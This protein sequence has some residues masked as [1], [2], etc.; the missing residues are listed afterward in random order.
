MTAGP[1]SHTTGQFAVV[2]ASSVSRRASAELYRRWRTQ[3]RRDYP[4]PH[5]RASGAHASGHSI[6]L[7]RH[8]AATLGG[9]CFSG[10][11]GRQGVT[12]ITAILV[13][14]LVGQSEAPGRV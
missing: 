4:G 7:L 13:T 8:H 14:A 9:T 11:D 10:G 2:T 1:R 5:R 3:R 6:P 12:T